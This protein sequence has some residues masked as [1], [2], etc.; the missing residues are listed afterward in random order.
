MNACRWLARTEKSIFCVV[1]VAHICIA[2]RRIRFHLSQNSKLRHLPSCFHLYSAFVP[3]PLL[4]PSVPTSIARSPGKDIHN[5]QIGTSRLAAD[6]P[7]NRDSRLDQAHVLRI[8]FTMTTLFSDAAPLLQCQAFS[9]YSRYTRCLPLAS[10]HASTAQRIFLYHI[11]LGSARSHDPRRSSV[12]SFW[13]L[14]Y[15]RSPHQR[16]I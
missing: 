7:R 1:L 4:V 13:W 15:D 12:H 9:L 10:L 16:S 3:R 11:G 8:V 5:R 6:P 2:C 14:L